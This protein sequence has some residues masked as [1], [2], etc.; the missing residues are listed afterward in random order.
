MTA[1][2]AQV[3]ADG[4]LI[5]LPRLQAL[6]TQENAVKLRDVLGA[7]LPEQIVDLMHDPR[8]ADI[9]ILRAAQAIL[10]ERGQDTENLG[11]AIDALQARASG[12]SRLH[13][14]V[15]PRCA[16]DGRSHLRDGRG[17]EPCSLCEG[18]GKAL[19]R[20][21]LL[22]IAGDVEPEL[23]GAYDTEQER[24]EAAQ[25][26]RRAHGPEDGLFRVD[27][28]ATGT[29]TVDTFSGAELE[30]QPRRCVLCRC[31]ATG[32]TYGFAVCGYHAD[33]S[34]DD[35][36]C[37]HCL[38]VQVGDHVRDSVDGTWRRVVRIDGL[39]DGGTAH[40]ADGGCMSLDECAVAEKRLPSEEL[41]S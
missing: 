14:S 7:V 21:H 18:T 13:E 11:V 27:V 41:P 32:E 16:G 22:S 36:R 40:L 23:S 12:P 39:A 1:V 15:C 3:Q 38:P 30:P 31:D 2:T 28:D 9:E 17:S 5:T 35:P 24:L 6:V 19:P 37:P 25:D 10:A 8:V 26:Y 34:E 4:V 33:H 20:L 29:V